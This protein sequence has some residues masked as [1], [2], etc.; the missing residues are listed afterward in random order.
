MALR[1]IKIFDTTLRDG[2]QSPGCSMHINEKI[3]LALQLEKLGVDIIEAGFAAS[4]P[5][6][7]DSVK[8][9]AGLVKNSAV[10]SLS[11]ALVAD[12]DKAYDAVKGAVSPR[13]HVFLATSPLHMQY[14]LKMSGEEVL[15]RIEES[16]KYAK[17]KLSD[18]EFS[19]EDASRSDRDFLK[20]A[21][22][23][24]IKSG[25]TVINIPDTVGYCTPGEMYD[26]IRF[27]RENVEGA[28]RVDLSAHNHNDLGLAVAN[29]LAMVEAGISQAECT[30]NGI[31]ERAGNA[32]LE[33]IVMGINTR[34]Y[35]Y[36]AETRINTKEIYKTCKL[37]SNIIGVNLHPTKP[38]V[39]ANVFAHESG[40]HQHGVLAKKETYE[41]LS[42]EAVGIPQNKI[43]LGKHSGKHAFSEHLTA[44][45][46]HDIGAEKIQELFDE[47]KRLCDIKKSVSNKDIEALLSN[48]K[49]ESNLKYVLDNFV[50]NCK[51]GNAYAAVSIKCGEEVRTAIQDGDGPIDSSFLA[52]DKIVGKSFVL[53]DYGVQSVGEGRDALGESYVRLA[54]DGGESV[55]GRGVSTDVIE[56]GILAYID[57]VNK[58][59][60]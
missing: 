44:M 17:S 26:L 57:A 36:N 53:Y 3:E 37:V 20:I 22:E 19:A 34:P 32:S 50:I 31:G 15:R 35:L 18:V 8:V 11:R 47:F 33:E 21:L 29:T 27:I 7:F 30:V 59:L 12:I 40:I 54:L 38:I 9:V 14:K 4:S 58:L 45:G 13:I 55:I 16:V 46:Y 56:S 43:V 5:G 49:L 60:A 42:P 41:I 2:E 39:G 51:K 1:R 28:D 52:V 23:T 48:K 6:D 10:A 25:A 24:A